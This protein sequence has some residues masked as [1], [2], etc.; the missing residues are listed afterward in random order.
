[1]GVIMFS[2]GVRTLTKI[3]RKN[4]IGAISAENL[5][6][7]VPRAVTSS[8]DNRSSSSAPSYRSSEESQNDV[9][10]VESAES[11]RQFL[12]R[13]DNFLFDCDGVLWGNDHVTPIPRIPEAIE[14]L[15]RENKR[16]IYVTNNSTKSRLTLQQKFLEYGFNSNLGH[17]FTNSYAC[18]LYL[19]GFLGVN[20]GVYMV[21]GEGTKWELD[22]MSI[23]NFGLGPDVDTPTSDVRSMIQYNCKEGVS[24]V[25]VGFDEHFSYNKMFKASTFLLNPSCHFIATNLVEKGVTIG[26]GDVK[27]RMPLTGVMV[28]A[29]AEASGR[30]PVVVGKPFSTMFEC[31]R[32]QF[33]DLN[34]SRTVFIGDNLKADM[35]FAK[36]VGMDSALV[37]TGVHKTSDIAE[38]PDLAPEYVLNSLTDILD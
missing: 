18:A 7:T 38:F 5:T 2:Y 36:S 26:E 22:Q 16:L 17:I 19:K 1:M 35:G 32:K 3:G 25:L 28:N 4:V 10:F 34:L 27:R 29:I 11:C 20:N 14:K 12:D 33:S 21:A 24:A 15:H 8:S 30:Q 13:Y 31:V 9:T 23:K 37:L 6:V